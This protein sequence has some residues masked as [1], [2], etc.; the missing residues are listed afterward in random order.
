LP[1]APQPRPKKFDLFKYKVAYL[2]ELGLNKAWAQLRTNLAQI[3]D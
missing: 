2:I 3:T 1:T